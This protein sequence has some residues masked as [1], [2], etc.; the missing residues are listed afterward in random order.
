[1]LEIVKLEIYREMS[2]GKF[3]TVSISKLSGLQSR[4][5]YFEQNE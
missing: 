3:I 1:M 5:K 4:A 2:F